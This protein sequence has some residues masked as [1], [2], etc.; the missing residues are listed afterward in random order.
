MKNGPLDSLIG[1]KTVLVLLLPQFIQP[2]II[3]DNEFAIPGLSKKLSYFNIIFAI[4]VIFKLSYFKW[5]SIPLP[6]FISFQSSSI[7]LNFKMEF[8][9]LFHPKNELNF[10]IWYFIIEFKNTCQRNN[11]FCWIFFSVHEL[12][13]FKSYREKHELLLVFVSMI[14][15]L[16]KISE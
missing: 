14:F 5:S 10:M 12:N 4:N 1:V 15:L 13:G 8:N 16:K 6:I 3:L 7:S 2:H 11:S 9:S